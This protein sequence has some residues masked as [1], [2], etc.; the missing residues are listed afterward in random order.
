MTAEGLLNVS[1]LGRCE[2]VRGNVISLQ[3]SG[4]LRGI[5][6]AKLGKPVGNFVTDNSLGPTF[7][8]GT[9]FVLG[10]NPDTVRAPDV[11][12]VSHDRMPDRLPPG[13][14]PGPPDLAVEFLFP[15]DRASEVATKTR[16]WLAAGCQEVWN[17]DPQTQTIT[18][19]RADGTISM[20]T[21]ANFLESPKLLPGFRLAITDLF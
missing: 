13:F 8:T 14:F 7:G 10:R 21:T 11:A 6:A 15:G 12:F 3:Y 1:G 9:G 20:L 17:V 5:L 4:A 16:D 18:V 2:L 19:H